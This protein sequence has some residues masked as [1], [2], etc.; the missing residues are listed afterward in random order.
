MGYYLHKEMGTEYFV[1]G[2]DFYYTTC[3]LP[4]GDGRSDYEFCSDDPL[5]EAV[6]DLDGNIYFLDFAKARESQ[7]LSKLIDDTIPTGSL[8]ESYSPMMKVMKSTYQV[9][10]PPVKLYDGIILVYEATPIQV[11][12]YME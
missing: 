4:D 12:D 7:E 1:I 9:K 11:W 3:N 2:T 10:I 8:G 6:G 5:A